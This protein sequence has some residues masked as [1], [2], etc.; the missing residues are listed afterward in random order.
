MAIGASGIVGRLVG[1][2]SPLV[3]ASVMSLIGLGLYP[4][5]ADLCST[6]WAVSIPCAL[7][8][9]ETQSYR[10]AADHQFDPQFE[11]LI[12]LFQEIEH[13]MISVINTSMPNHQVLLY[14]LAI[15]SHDPH[16]V[17]D[18]LCGSFAHSAL[19]QLAEEATGATET[20]DA[21]SAASQHVLS[22]THT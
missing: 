18:T 21:R 4:V 13:L 17:A 22:T 1:A 12:H 5:A 7:L 16:N 9:F 14:S 3:L 2:V 10:T 15:Q 11:N 20:G 8:P 19:L 6:N